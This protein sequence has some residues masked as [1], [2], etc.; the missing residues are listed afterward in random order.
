M[1]I[2]ADENMPY[3]HLLFAP[4]GEVALT[5]GRAIAPE[6]VGDADALMV[7]SVT[8]VDCQLLRDSQVAF[9]GSATAGTDHVDQTW[10]QQQGIAF[11]AAP[12]CNAVAVVEYVF[13]ALLWL[14]QRDDFKLCD[15]VVG[16]VG[17][18]QVGSRLQQRLQAWGVTVLLCDPP[19]ADAGDAGEF[20]SLASVVAQAD[21]ITFHTPLISDGPYR[22]EYLAD[23]ALLNALRPNTIL[24]N[25]SRGAVVDNAALYHVLQTRKDL[26]VVLDVWESEPELSLPLMQCV[27]IATP[28]I[29]GYSLEGKARG[30]LQIFSAWTQ[31]IHQPQQ[32]QLADL[33][34]SAPIQQVTLSGYLDQRVLQSLVHLVYDVR[35]DDA[36]L[37]RVAARPGQFD[38]LRKH[39]PERREWSALQIV[40]PCTALADKLT[41]LGFD[42]RLCASSG[43]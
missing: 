7:R 42:A 40:C 2:I 1:K 30:S 20:V 36:A 13:S 8:R 22:S 37:R 15:R 33:L 26:C 16:I 32:V 5:N 14:A 38:Q 12:G 11:S 18:G 39:Y 19:R 43:N 3:A 29:A 9:V 10:L 41:S 35:A 31:F 23:E 27:D 21:I 17:V 25:A 24:I 4:F 34:P 28:H 6:T